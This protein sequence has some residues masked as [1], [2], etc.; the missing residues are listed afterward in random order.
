MVTILEWLYKFA[1]KNLSKKLFSL[2][3]MWGKINQCHF[4][5]LRAFVTGHPKYVLTF[6]VGQI[7]NQCH[8]TWDWLEWR[9]CA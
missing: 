7:N 9:P 5:D 1:C 4:G 8:G 3:P 6:G 2:A